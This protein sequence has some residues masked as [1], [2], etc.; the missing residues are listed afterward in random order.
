VIRV[1]PLLKFSTGHFLAS[2]RF[3][4]ERKYRAH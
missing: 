4:C 3:R 1:A 2:L